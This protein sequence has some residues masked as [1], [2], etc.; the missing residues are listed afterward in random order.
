MS[1]TLKSLLEAG[2]HFGHQTK[3]W[4]P[5]MKRFILCPKNGIYIID[6]N[7]TVKCLD[8]FLSLVKTEV[9]RGGEVL[10]VGTKKQVKD[11][12]REEA[13]RCGMP[14]VTERWLGGMLT[15][16]KTIRQSIAKLEKI[17][18]MEND[19]TMSSLPKKE[20]LQ[21]MKKKEKL[22]MVLGGIRNLKKSPAIIFVVDSIKEDIA[23]QEAKRLRIPIG[24]M[25]DTNSDPDP[26][27]FPI[28]ANDDA[29]KSVQLITETVA[30]TVLSA[31]EKYKVKELEE[32]AKREAEKKEKADAKKGDAGSAEDGDDR[33]KKRRV[34]KKKSESTND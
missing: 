24:A 32:A 3:R 27:D 12:I 29:I 13:E 21:L 5:K 10:F 2:V 14:Y 1:V 25:V 34:V 18:R 23:V 9:E 30:N 16:F 28:P 20:V 6:L 15:N 31:R 19:G 22:L 8:N 11:C 7:K 26:I 17:E 4:N 33:P